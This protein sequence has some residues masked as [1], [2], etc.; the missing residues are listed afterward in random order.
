[1]ILAA[2]TSWKLGLTLVVLCGP[3]LM[4]KQSTGAMYTET[5]TEKFLASHRK[6][7]SK[8]L[9]SG[10]SKYKLCDGLREKQP[11]KPSHKQQVS[12]PKE[13]IHN[14]KLQKKSI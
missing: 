4:L 12:R 11:L 8:K 14:I 2:L 13:E 3:V 9:C 1:M 6:G 10:L 5:S 7:A